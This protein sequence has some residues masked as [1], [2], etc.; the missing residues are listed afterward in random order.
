MSRMLGCL[1]LVG[2]LAVSAA[3]SD[4]EASEPS[5]TASLSTEAAPSTASVATTVATTDAPTTATVPATTTTVASMVEPAITSGPVIGG[6]GAA[7]AAR[8]DLAALGYVE[9]EYFVAGDAASYAMDGAA[10]TDG[11]WTVTAGPTAPY[12]T[13]VIVRRPAEAA[14]E[15]SVP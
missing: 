4:D 14:A 7:N 1:A 2:A 8:Q 3:C 12:R 10:T 6:N 11:R 9:E 5:A 15:S 13:R